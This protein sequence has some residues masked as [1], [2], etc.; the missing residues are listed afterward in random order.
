MHSCLT[1]KLYARQMLEEQKASTLAVKN[2][3]SLIGDIYI[4]I[5]LHQ[6]S[7]HSHLSVGVPACHLSILKLTAFSHLKVGDWL[8]FQPV[9]HLSILPWYVIPSL[10]LCQQFPSLKVGAS[11][12]ANELANIFQGR[13]MAGLFQGLC[14]CVYTNIFTYHSV[15]IYKYN[16]YVYINYMYIYIMYIYICMESSYSWQN[17]IHGPYN[18]YTIIRGY[19]KLPTA[20]QTR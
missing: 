3:P 6:Q 17:T 15:Y 18:H 16:I 10:K 11:F 8:V 20:K 14:V 7:Q 2:S 12:G 4:Y 1:T 5:H 19:N 13:W 9:S